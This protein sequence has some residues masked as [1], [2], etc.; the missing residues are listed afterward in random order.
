MFTAAIV[1]ALASFTLGVLYH[2]YV[3]AK[4]SAAE[5]LAHSLKQHVTAEVCAL[6]Q[7]LIK[8]VVRDKTEIVDLA[9]GAEKKL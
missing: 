6:R 1:T 7:D 4:V 2:K 5:A 8:M 3:I 9:E